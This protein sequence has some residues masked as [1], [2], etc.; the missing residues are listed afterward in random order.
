MQ[1]NFRYISYFQVLHSSGLYLLLKFLF[2]EIIMLSEDWG[3]TLGKK[4]LKLKIT[5]SIV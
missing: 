1:S 4:L 3:F 2:T 5:T